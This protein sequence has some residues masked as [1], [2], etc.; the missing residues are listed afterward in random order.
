M[1]ATQIN[2]DKIKCNCSVV[3]NCSVSKIQILFQLT[4][5]LGFQ[6]IF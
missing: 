4:L 1:L 2:S 6:L 3:L 5:Q